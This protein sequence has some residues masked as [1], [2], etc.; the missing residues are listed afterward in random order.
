MII[1]GQTAGF[2]GG[3]TARLCYWVDG[4]ENPSDSGESD[5][6]GI[7]IF[8][9]SAKKVLYQTYGTLSF[10]TTLT[11]KREGLQI[12]VDEIPNIIKNTMSNEI[13]MA[14]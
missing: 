1:S 3:N 9:S 7:S 5:N 12:L 10:P 8:D 6:F 14:L 4:V 13:T 11:Y 2:N